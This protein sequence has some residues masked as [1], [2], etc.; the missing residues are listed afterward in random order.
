MKMRRFA[1]ALADGMCILAVCYFILVVYPS[2]LVKP[3]PASVMIHIALVSASIFL[4]RFLFRVYR[5]IWR[6]AGSTEYIRLAAADFCAGW[7]YYALTEFLLPTRIRVSFVREISLVALSLL[8]ALGI[9]FV[10]KFLREFVTRPWD[11]RG[12]MKSLRIFLRKRVCGEDPVREELERARTDIAIVG[13]GTVGVMLAE[14]LENNPNSRYRPR[15]FIDNNPEKIG[16]EVVGIPVIPERMEAL[17][18]LRAYA[19]EEVVFAMPGMPSGRKME[20][21]ERYA[22][23]GYKVKIYDYPLERASEDGRRQLREF[24]I[25]ELL[26]RKPVELADER[27]KS[28]YQGKTALVTGG[29]GSIGSE[30]CR[31]IARLKPARLVILDIYE[32]NAYDVEQELRLAY[33][34]KLDL[35]VEIASVRDAG[36]IDEILGRYRP[37]IVFHAAAHKHVPLM[38]HCAGEAVKNNVFG[39]LNVAT[40]AERHGVSKFILVSTDKAVNPTNV[41]GATKRL[42]EMIVQSRAGGATSFSVTRFGNVLGSNGSVIP[43][44]KR[45]IASGGPVTITDKR[46]IRYF[47]TI[48]EAAQLVLQSGAMAQSGELYVLDMGTPVRILDLAEN[49]IRLTGLQPYKDVDI[50]E[51]GL[52][53]GEKLY[54]EL[55]IRPERVEKTSSDRIFIERDAPLSRAE[56]GRRLAQLRRALESGGNEA[57]RGALIKAVPTYQTPE[58]ANSRAGEAEEFI[59]ANARR[60]VV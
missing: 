37:E 9:R 6:Y 46:I 49:M 17:E 2:S 60:A 36:R 11:G 18:T 30:L 59:R 52:R 58:E 42:C 1:L 50:V 48:P 47:M 14:E 12:S 53:P 40:A 32:N 44:F 26:F 56:I 4:L 20:L 5:Q 10:Y 35:A 21:Y 25:D 55:L 23:A 3:A 22:R 38:E 57:I 34:A 7:L 45:Q 19:V 8:M 39:T 28:F 43:L 54:E 33:G 15:C 13:A 41:M 24:G 27:T 31:Q 16:R 51:I 29:G